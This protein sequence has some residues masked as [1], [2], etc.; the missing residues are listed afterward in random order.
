M[1]RTTPL[2]IA[3]CSGFYG[4]R[5]TA[6]RE[7]VDG[8]P[9]DVLTGDYLAELT[10][11]VL[12]KNRQR[13]AS[14]GYAVS[15]LTQ[16]RDVL[17]TCL[18]RGTK[19][20]VNAGGLNPAG[21]ARELEK[22]ASEVGR[23]PRIAHIEGDDLL[24]RL[25][26]L[27][28][29]G[30][31]LA[32]LDTGTRLADAGVE[33]V[34]A[35]AYLGA[36]GIVEALNAD[37]DIVICPRVTDAS[38]VV[39]PAAWAFGWKPDDWDRLAGAV[40]AGHII[41]CGP[42]ATGGNFSF[43]TE[44]PDPVRPGFPIAE[45]HPDG[46]C[47]ITKHPGTAGMVTPETVTAQLLYEIDAPA[48]RNPDVVTRFDTVRLAQEG[49]D[50]VAVTGTR[51]EAAPGTYKVS[52][53]YRGGYRNSV[54]FLLTGLNVEAKAKF[55]EDALFDGLGGRDQFGRVETAL[56]RTDH[57]DAALN[58]E[59]AARFTV[60]VKDP[61]SEKVGRRFFDASTSLSLSNY[62][63]LF[64]ERADRRA[65]EYGVY[66]PAIVPSD[67]VT[68]TVVRPDGERVEV[69]HPPTGPAPSA[70]V[71]PAAAPPPPESA[72]ATR[73]LPLG[74]VAGA[75]SGDKGGNANVGLWARTD[76]GYAW[77]RAYL[78]EA[79]MRELLPEA[80]GLAISRYELPNLRAVN[81]VVHGLLGEGVAASSRQDPQAKGLGEYVRGRYA[82]IPVEILPEEAAR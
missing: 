56:V 62:P 11:L 41:E 78:T 70:P 44:I 28:R 75:R 63:G 3:N 40:T 26:E 51:G 6:A 39:G 34:T 68:Q 37:A 15:L 52:I 65:A 82:D 49:P 10:M 42:Q 4:D 79:R 81:F 12:W 72:G 9:I 58:A 60:T 50:R 66:W 8:G 7:M 48:Y 33:P 2:R 29:D 46:S 5:I 69:P 27:Q 35:N 19:I 43:F 64:S 76:D 20:V 74:T 24:P 30:H 32:N 22:L 21:L 71:E 18:D 45:M 77:L 59:A 38:V 25:P 14:R 17:T 1:T 53:N 13:D 16:M 57:T 55:A 67:V 73:H 23:R 47:V 31:D 54:T 36:W 80:G 61:D